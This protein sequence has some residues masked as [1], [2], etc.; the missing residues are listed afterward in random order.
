[1]SAEMDARLDEV[2]IG[3]REQRA[4][5]IA[6]YDEAWPIRAADLAERVRSALGGTALTVEHIGSTAVPGLAAKPILDLLLVVHDVADEGA[7][8]AQLEAAGLVLR[9]REPR[10]RMFRTP[11]KDVHLHVYAEGSPEIDAYL[12]LRDWL[13]IDRD[14]RNFYEATKH[15]LAQ[16]QWSDMNYYADAKSP[17]ITE[18]LGRARAWR[19]ASAGEPDRGAARP[20]AA[21]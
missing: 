15:E 17:V 19:A 2:L 3:G 18:I 20:P 10:H 9:V 8:V 12:D 7:Y 13:R 5:V 4:I 1:M 16:R 11:E 6:E 21:G 14:D